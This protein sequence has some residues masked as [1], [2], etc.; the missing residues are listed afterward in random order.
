[1]GDFAVLEDE[2]ATLR[3]ELDEMEQI[4]SQTDNDF[5]NV[6]REALEMESQYEDYQKNADVEIDKLNKVVQAKENELMNL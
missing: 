3:H 5:F 6:Q 2:N 1:M 4:F